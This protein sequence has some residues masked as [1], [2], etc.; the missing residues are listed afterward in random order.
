MSN[1]G[2]TRCETFRFVNRGYSETGTK[3]VAAAQEGRNL[4]NHGFA[5]REIDLEVVGLPR[6]QVLLRRNAHRLVRWVVEQH[7][8]VSSR[9]CWLLLG[10]MFMKRN[11]CGTPPASVTGPGSGLPLRMGGASSPGP[12][13]PSRKINHYNPHS[14]Q[15]FL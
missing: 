6:P 7:L 13:Q 9:I 11:R 12:P 1:P 4:Q 2:Q 3:T 14:P 8:A 15:E 5:R 10:V